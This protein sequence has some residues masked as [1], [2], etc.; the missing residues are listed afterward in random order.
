MSVILEDMVA[1]VARTRAKI[2]RELA[3][4]HCGMRIGDLQL[5]AAEEVRSGLDLLM[6]E[7]R[8]LLERWERV[9]RRPPPPIGHRP[10]GPL[11]K[12]E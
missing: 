2:E 7:Q 6:D 5:L 11:R 4:R 9:G 10:S 1:R 8:E 12:H 3:R